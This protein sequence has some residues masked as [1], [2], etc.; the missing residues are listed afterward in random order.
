M[1]M[2]C[3]AVCTELDAGHQRDH[4]AEIR[5]AAADPLIVKSNLVRSDQI[6]AGL[7]HKPHHRR[8]APF[9]HVAGPVMDLQPRA[10]GSRGSGKR[11]V[12]LLILALHG[13][14][15]DRADIA[16]HGQ[17]VRNDVDR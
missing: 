12:D 9:R 2:A 11:S 7:L 5:G 13:F 14:H 3:R 4:V 17:F 1:A 10:H 8:E 16:F 15:G 6:D